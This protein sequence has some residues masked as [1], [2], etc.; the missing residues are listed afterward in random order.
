MVSTTSNLAFLVAQHVAQQAAE[1]ADVF[2]Q[3]RV[4]VGGLGI[5]LC[6][7]VHY[8]P[9]VELSEFQWARHGQGC[10][11]GCHGSARGRMLKFVVPGIRQ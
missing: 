9:Q 8:W 10:R 7:L 11:G 1:Q 5:S 4:L 3:R 2:F 6:S